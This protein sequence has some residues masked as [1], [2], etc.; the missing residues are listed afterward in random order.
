MKL[1]DK[2]YDINARIQEF[3]IGKDRELDI[4]LAKYDV[5]GSKAHT[6]MLSSIG[7][8]E[9]EENQQLQEEMDNI[10]TVIEAGEFEIEEGIEDVHSQVEL[11][12][13]RELGDIGKKIHL[14]RSRNDQVLLDLRL[15]FRDQLDLI[16]EGSGQLASLLIRHADKDKEVLMP[17]YTHMQI[18]MVSS[19]GMWFGGYAE[20][21]IDDIDFVKAVKRVVNRNPLGTA[22]GYGSSIP[23]DR[24]MTTA[25]L[26]FE[27]LCINPIN[28]QI[29]RGKTEMQVADAI[30]SIALTLNKMAM[31]ICL[32]TNENYHFMS[33]PKE[34]TT[35][36]S[37]MP[38]KK[39]PDVFELIRAKTNLLIALPG[40]IASMISNLSSGYHRDFQ[41]QKEILFPAIFEIQN[42]LSLVIECI[43]NLK[44]HDTKVYD[45]QYKYLWSVEEVNKNVL[46]GMTFR[47]AYKKVGMDIEAGKYDPPQTIEHTHIGS[48]NN[49]GLDR[50]QGR[51]DRILES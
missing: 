44:I 41:L 15:F 7:L 20:A 48:I 1:W 49:L 24:D 11:M 42:I 13:I 35:G 38:H 14:G 23:L 9:T 19:F 32:F 8:I 28:A 36:S 50:M 39:N 30:A 45:E 2:G 29:G 10:L 17:G 12:L 21:L 33:L 3:T 26:E 5:L 43:P 51:L 40:Q 27:G 47:D 22:A 18:G 16:S 25:N 6:A 4:Y 37:I 34:Y 31:D 46:G